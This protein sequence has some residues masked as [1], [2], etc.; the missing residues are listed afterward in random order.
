VLAVQ[1]PLQTS[2]VTQLQVHSLLF[3]SLPGVNY[4]TR[5]V[6]LFLPLRNKVSIDDNTVHVHS[7]V[8]VSTDGDF[9]EGKTLFVTLAVCFYD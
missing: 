1:C 8:T 3:E 7:G 2:P 6:N 9:S 4:V 5:G